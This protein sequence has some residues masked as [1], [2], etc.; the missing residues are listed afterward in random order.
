MA[1]YLYQNSLEATVDNSVENAIEIVAYVMYL[2]KRQAD[3]PK[4]VVELAELAEPSVAEL[5]NHLAATKRN[6]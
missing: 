6:L 4:L 2:I 1:R 5:L 3:D